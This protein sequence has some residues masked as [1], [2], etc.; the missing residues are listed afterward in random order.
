MKDAVGKATVVAYGGYRGTG[1]II[2]HR[3]ESG[4]AELHA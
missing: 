4:R 2:P 1:L 3:R